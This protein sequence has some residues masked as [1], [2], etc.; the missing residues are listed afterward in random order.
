MIVNFSFIRFKQAPAGN[1][2]MSLTLTA[3]DPKL[4]VPT[5]QESASVDT[6]KFSPAETKVLSDFISL[7]KSKL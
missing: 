7:M 3:N 2:G 6:D 1:N 4:P 5:D